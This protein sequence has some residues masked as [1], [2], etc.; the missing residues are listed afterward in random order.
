MRRSLRRS[1]E[2]SVGVGVVLLSSIIVECVFGIVLRRL[3]HISR[4]LDV[5]KPLNEPSQVS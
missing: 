4:V 2:K 1:G 3:I 5:F